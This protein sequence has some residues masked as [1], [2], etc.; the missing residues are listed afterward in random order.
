MPDLAQPAGI[1]AESRATM[2]NQSAFIATATDL[3][4]IDTSAPPVRSHLAKC[5]LLV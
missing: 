4:V 2:L 3:D 1:L 5:V